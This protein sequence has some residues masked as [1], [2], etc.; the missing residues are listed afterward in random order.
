[1]W[2]ERKIIKAWEAE[3]KDEWHSG[4]DI[5]RPG[6]NENGGPFYKER[7]V[8]ELWKDGAEEMPTKA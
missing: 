8:L 4:R 5:L 7:T 2:E 3:P 6:W 1:M